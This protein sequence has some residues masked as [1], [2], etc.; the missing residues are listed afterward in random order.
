MRK[1]VLVLIFRHK[2]FLGD[3]CK[4]EVLN[5]QPYANCIRVSWQSF[6]TYD[7]TNDPAPYQTDILMTNELGGGFRGTSYSE[8]KFVNGIP[9]SSYNRRGLCPGAIYAF[10]IELMYKS[11]PSISY[12]IPGRAPTAKINNW[13]RDGIITS[14][15]T[16]GGNID[17][18]VG[19]D[20]S[21]VNM[22][23]AYTGI[24][25][26]PLIFMMNGYQ[27]NIVLVTGGPN[28]ELET[29]GGLIVTDCGDIDPSIIDINEWDLFVGEP[30]AF[31]EDDLLT[32]PGYNGEESDLDAANGNL[33]KVFHTRE[34]A[35]AGRMGYWENKDETYPDTAD[36]DVFDSGGNIIGNIR[37]QNVRHHVAPSVRTLNSSPDFHRYVPVPTFS[38]IIIPTELLDKISGYRIHYS[39][40]EAE[41]NNV[42]GMS[43][44]LDEKWFNAPAGRTGTNQRLYSLTPLNF[45]TGL[46]VD[47]YQREG[48]IRDVGNK[49]HYD[50][51]YIETLETGDEIAIVDE[52]KYL[53]ENNTQSEPVNEHREECIHARVPSGGT[54]EGYSNTLAFNGY[55]PGTQTFEFVTLKKILFNVYAGFYEQ[56][57]ASTN[58]I[59]P[60]TTAGIKS[61]YDVN[62][63]DC[64]IT[65]YVGMVR[66]GDLDT[67]PRRG[68]YT[69][70][71]A[72]TSHIYH[73]RDETYSGDFYPY[74][75]HEDFLSV[76]N[77]TTPPIYNPYLNYN[78]RFPYRLSWSA[79]TNA[80]QQY[81][82][83][84]IFAVEDV[85]DKIRNRG[86]L[87]H[88]NNFGRFLIM[89]FKDGL[90][91]QFIR[92]VLDGDPT[93]SL[94][95]YV[96]EGELFDREPTEIIDDN[97][98]YVGCDSKF[99][100]LVCKYGYISVDRRVGKVFLFNGE[101]DEIS[102]KGV[103]NYLRDNL[104]T[105]TDLDIDNPY[106][107]NGVC[108]GFDELHDRL[109]VSKPDADSTKA[110]TIS[111]DLSRKFWVANHSYY[112]RG[113]YRDKKDLFGIFPEAVFQFNS[114][115]KI[116][117]Y[118][119]QPTIYTSYVD[120][121]FAL[122]T[123][124]NKPKTV[125]FN[126]VRWST[127]VRKT[128]DNSYLKNETLTDI[129][130]YNDHQ[131]SDEVNLDAGNTWYDPNYKNLEGWWSFN[132][133][134]DL[135]IDPSVP[136]FDANGNVLSGNI[137]SGQPWFDKS[138][139]I[140][141]FIIVRFKYDNRLIGD[142]Q[143]HI[144]IS[145]VG[146]EVSPV[147]LDIK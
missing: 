58:D 96:G 98:G 62:G 145:D 34:T 102:A 16:G 109:I 141:N 7:I 27:V 118:N 10:Y 106:N 49:T 41:N 142:E 112:A 119:D 40:R 100:T 9:Y 127:S 26:P 25:D 15:N 111:Y 92:D 53:P 17:I 51:N 89:Q 135:V 75:I 143:R 139:F 48:T 95:T 84:R 99:G 81:E 33:L 8:E 2:L 57:L 61:H 42:V 104:V 44:V 117:Q 87:Y 144:Y 66:E 85:Y 54:A 1:M 138:D 124:Q 82:N 43:A 90:Y 78:T 120:A 13:G 29:N 137:N 131:C 76:Q 123:E 69:P 4:D 128:N 22:V 80:E 45:K 72:Q 21:F 115:S 130:V 147:T 126:T 108:I 50:F 38:N 60:V 129:I 6:D 83:W 37:N 36:F 132:D 71:Y 46:G 73:E 19:G 133:F 105:S 3:L 107:N 64:F 35:Q 86:D 94:A 5:Y 79:E 91:V 97:L 121:V 20:V 23:L 39:I 28:I 68:I 134:H 77:L 110:L 74:K 114:N 12:H 113:F 24:P 88:L 14:V 32:V 67:D 11:G 140:S 125:K 122:R 101:I 52:V 56:N 47:F 18:D 146:V 59:V 116:G 136:I 30:A 70:E 63:F 103:R 55:V 31:N 93:N 65:N